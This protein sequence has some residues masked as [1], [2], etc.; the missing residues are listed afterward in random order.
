MRVREFSFRAN[1]HRSIGVS[2]SGWIDDEH[3][4][5]WFRNA[6]L[7]QAQARN[8]SGKPILLICDGHGSHVTDTLLL[9]AKNNNVIVLVLPPHCTHK[10]QPLDVGVLGPLQTAYADQVDEHVISVGQG[11]SKPEFITLYT[12][13]RRQSV[14]KKLIEDA[15]RHCGIHPLNP[16]IFTDDDFAPSQGF[17]TV[18]SSHLPPSFPTPDTS[19]STNPDASPSTDPDTLPSIDPDASPPTDPPDPNVPPAPTPDTHK[20]DGDSDQE[21]AGRQSQSSSES[22]SDTDDDDPRAADTTPSNRRRTRA[23]LSTLSTLHPEYASLSKEKLVELLV[24]RDSEVKEAQDRAADSAKE[25]ATAKAHALLAGQQ[26]SVLQQEKNAKS[27]ARSRTALHTTARVAN[28]AEEIERIQQEQAD[29]EKWATQKRER[30]EMAADVP[31]WAKI[32]TGALATLAPREARRKKAQKAALLT[33]NK[34]V[35]EVARR[36]AAVEKG[37]EK[38]V[39]SAEIAVKKAEAETKRIAEREAKKAEAAAKKAE[40]EAKKVADREAKKAG[41]AAKKAEVEARKAAEREA[42][43][44]SGTSTRTRRRKAANSGADGEEIDEGSKQQSAV[45]LS[46]SSGAPEDVFTDTSAAR[47]RRKLA[48]EIT[49]GKE[50]HDTSDQE[51]VSGSQPGTP[52]P[53]PKRPRPK[54]RFTGQVAIEEKEI[55]PHSGSGGIL[56]PMRT[57]R[58]GE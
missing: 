12:T 30:E 50:N 45:R 1:P 2:S 40:A 52:Q 27:A 9:E 14:K 53:S 39:R 26:V 5:Q 8:K 41:A 54:P 29:K 33:A 3:C 31:L 7:P 4:V 17:S 44:A 22:E 38:A 18:A 46:A 25:A 51:M 23:S 16:N 34:A 47:K 11:I 20:D 43:K 36:E 57:P 21:S 35:L 42:K 49:L 13:A 6:F 55:E 24:K 15:F 19:L 32:V 28:S 37:V 10:L 56:S 58:R 48:Q